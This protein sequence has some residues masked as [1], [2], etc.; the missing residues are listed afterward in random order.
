[1]TVSIKEYVPPGYK[2]Y[3]H[4]DALP[5]S[6]HDGYDNYT[7][8]HYGRGCNLCTTLRHE[9]RKHISGEPAKLESLETAR[10]LQ[11]A[12]GDGG[13]CSYAAA[14][15]RGDY[16]TRRTAEGSATSIAASVG[17]MAIVGPASVC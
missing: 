6:S 9:W 16:T 3:V 7:T 12:Q 1:M 17:L 14:L 8:R 4:P 5:S 13:W 11:C 15:S 2:R 10:Q